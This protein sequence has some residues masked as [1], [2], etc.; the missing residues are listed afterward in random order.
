MDTHTVRR[1]LTKESQVPPEIHSSETQ[2]RGDTEGACTLKTHTGSA[3]R[4][5]PPPSNEHHAC[6]HA[7]EL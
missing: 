6:L 2:S 1:C 3:K 5:P 4:H 7:T